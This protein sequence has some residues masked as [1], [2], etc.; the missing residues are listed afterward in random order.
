MLW[1]CGWWWF[2]VTCIAIRF[3]HTYHEVLLSLATTNELTHRNDFETN[4]VADVSITSL[5]NHPK[6]GNW[7]RRSSR[8]SLL[9]YKTMVRTL[10]ALLQ[11]GTFLQKA[12]TRNTQPSMFLGLYT[13]NNRITRSTRKLYTLLWVIIIHII[14]TWLISQTR[15]GVDTANYTCARFMSNS[16]AQSFILHNRKLHTFSTTNNT[17]SALLPV[18]NRLH[19]LKELHTEYQWYLSLKYI[20]CTNISKCTKRHFQIHLP[21]R[22]Q[23]LSICKFHTLRDHKVML[24]IQRVQEVKRNKV[25]RR[26]TIKQKLKL[27]TQQFS[28]QPNQWH[29]SSNGTLTIHM[30]VAQTQFFGGPPDL[31]F[32][33][34]GWSWKQVFFRWPTLPQWWQVGR[35]LCASWPACAAPSTMGA[36]PGVF[37][38]LYCDAFLKWGCCWR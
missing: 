6:F 22:F 7:Y 27:S 10:G 11:N 5:G 31:G 19:L 16:Y 29:I 36:G 37:T 13:G 12:A 33:S 26:A 25:A 15:K 9:M 17:Y 20:K 14:T 32:F 35:G 18:H 34:S 8:S 2:I 30:E 4:C 1:W 28:R 21:T 38:L 24:N 3:K 23:H